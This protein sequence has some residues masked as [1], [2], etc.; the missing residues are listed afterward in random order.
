MEPV[1]KIQS[2]WWGFT[3]DIPRGGKDS[4]KAG[5]QKRSSS[6]Y[7]SEVKLQELPTSANRQLTDFQN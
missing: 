7:C 3:S 5:K 2:P 6:D 1:I 4:T